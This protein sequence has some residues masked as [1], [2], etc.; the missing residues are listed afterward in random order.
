LSWVQR[1]GEVPGI[2]AARSNDLTQRLKEWKG[3]T[4]EVVVRAVRGRASRPHLRQ[5]IEAGIDSW[6]EQP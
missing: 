3:I 2:A 5:L 1:N 6:T 4:D